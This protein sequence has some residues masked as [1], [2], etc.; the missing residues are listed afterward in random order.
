MV[1]CLCND[2][3]Q[4]WVINYTSSPFLGK[5]QCKVA[6]LWAEETVTIS[7]GLSFCWFLRMA[8]RASPV[9]ILLSISYQGGDRREL[10]SLSLQRGEGLGSGEQLNSVSFCR[11]TEAEWKRKQFIH[12]RTRERGG[13]P[14]F[15]DAGVAFQNSLEVAHFKRPGAALVLSRF[16]CYSCGLVL[17]C[18]K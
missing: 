6:T 10:F 4:L 8:T 1:S 16:S 5:G 2:I 17:G 3:T 13:R 14:V 15:K 9:A 18:Y 11:K 7:G 12:N